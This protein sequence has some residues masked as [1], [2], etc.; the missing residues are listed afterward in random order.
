LKPGRRCH[1]DVFGSGE[2]SSSGSIVCGHFESDDSEEGVTRI[3]IYEG[4]T[5]IKNDIYIIPKIFK[6]L[7]PKIFKNM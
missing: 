5:K 1:L 2:S 6:N 7:I 3:K 4:A